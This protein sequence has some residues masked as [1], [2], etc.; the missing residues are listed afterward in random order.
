MTMTIKKEF[1]LEAFKRIGVSSRNG[2]QNQE[3][4]Q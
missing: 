1:P 4:A 3:A 2:A